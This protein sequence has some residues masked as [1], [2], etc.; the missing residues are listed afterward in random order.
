MSPFEVILLTPHLKKQLNPCLVWL[1]DNNK[2]YANLLSNKRNLL[3]MAGRRP[4][5]VGVI[6]STLLNK[7][8]FHVVFVWLVQKMKT[9]SKY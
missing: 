4:R 7:K 8:P 3:T 9:S 2:K 1:V 6:L 5:W